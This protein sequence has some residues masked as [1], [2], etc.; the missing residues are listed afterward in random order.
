MPLQF[1]M[2]SGISCDM[3]MAALLCSWQVT[4][5]CK[6]WAGFCIASPVRKKLFSIQQSGEN[7]KENIFNNAKFGKY[8][9][10]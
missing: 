2:G 1:G 7:P 9:N 5:V 10:I 6:L 8:I 4:P 3:G